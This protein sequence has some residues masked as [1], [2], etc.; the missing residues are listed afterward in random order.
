LRQAELEQELSNR[1]DE[2][3]LVLG[4]PSILYASFIPLMQDVTDLL[5]Y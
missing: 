3:L 2:N 1:W 4:A 5:I